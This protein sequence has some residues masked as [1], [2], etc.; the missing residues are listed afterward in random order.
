MQL[1]PSDERAGRTIDELIEASS[2]G[3]PEA[4][5]IRAQA[6]PALVDRVLKRVDELEAERAD[7]ECNCNPLENTGGGHR[8]DCP[9]FEPECTCYEMTGGH[10]PMC[11][12]G[13]MLHSKKAAE[14]AGAEQGEAT[15]S[16][17][18]DGETVAIEAERRAPVQ[19]RGSSGA[20][21]Y[22][23]P[24]T[25]AWAEHEQ[26]FERYAARYGRGQSAERIAERGG[27]GY[28]EIVMFTG[29]EPKTWKPNDGSA[30]HQ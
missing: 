16:V 15:A 20:P 28:G 13:V 17:R 7:P 3:T 27:F 4:K 30:G 26:V 1:A 23:P 21:G 18:L 10:Q 29:A 14:R 9:A 6:D 5:A 19:E 25:I 11:P 2:L 22:R 24:G 8:G 12:Y